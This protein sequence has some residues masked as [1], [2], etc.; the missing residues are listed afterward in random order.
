MFSA[1]LTVATVEVDRNGVLTIRGIA[2]GITAITVTAANR[3]DAR[4]SQTFAVT[5]R[6]PAQVALFPSASDPL[7]REGFVRVV[8]HSQEAGEVS[9]EAIDDS[10]TAPRPVMLSVAGN[11]AA[12]FNSGDLENGGP[13]KGLSGGV[14]SGEGDWRLL[15][16]SELEFEVLS[17][18]R[19][20]D[21]LLTAMHDVVPFVDGVYR[22]V[23]FNP[24]SNANQVS[25]LRLVNP[26]TEPA[27]VVISGVDDAGESPGSEVALMIPAGESVTLTASDLESGADLDGAL[28]DGMGKWRLRVESDEPIVVMSLLQSPTGHL[29]NL[30]TVP[31]RRGGA[32]PR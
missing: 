5:V 10:G 22:V 6:G 31:G 4:V 16:D 14:G 28:G 8:N 2:R 30:S 19:S 18:I 24:E 1:N 7:D 12:H 3:R 25:R 23:L 32:P 26:V 15:L 13:G 29:T 21:G 20:A 11:A 27:E 17:Y 9:V